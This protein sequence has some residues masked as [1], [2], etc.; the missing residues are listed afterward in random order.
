MNPMIL[1][2]DL[3]VMVDGKNS[4]NITFEELRGYCQNNPDWFSQW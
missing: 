1:P 4:W 3:L 2:G